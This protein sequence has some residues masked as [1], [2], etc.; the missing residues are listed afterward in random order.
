M[1]LRCSR[2]EQCLL[3]IVL[4]VL[5]ATP[6]LSQAASAIRAGPNKAF[7]DSTGRVASYHSRILFL[8]AFI[9]SRLGDWRP[10]RGPYIDLRSVCLL[11]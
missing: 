1:T 9:H 7:Y 10:P 4:A 5:L 8:A 6:G 11:F 2:Q 3:G